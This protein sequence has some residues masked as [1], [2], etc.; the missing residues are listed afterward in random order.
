VYVVKEM[1]VV[2]HQ[3]EFK[4]QEQVVEDNQPLEHL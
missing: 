2:I 4:T 1:L 3:Q